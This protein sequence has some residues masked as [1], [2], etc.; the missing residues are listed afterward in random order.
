M[1]GAQFYEKLAEAGERMVWS[2]CPTTGWL[3]GRFR[4]AKVK[5]SFCPITAVCYLENKKYYNVHHADFAAENMNLNREFAANIMRS[6]D[7]RGS[8]KVRRH[9]MRTLNV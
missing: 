3:R 1:T 2:V 8:K 5:R 9:L 6:A 4:Y 7:G